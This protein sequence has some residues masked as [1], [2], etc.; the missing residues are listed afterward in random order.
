[1]H[2]LSK[3][4]LKDFV[5]ISMFVLFL[6]FFAS[7]V[8]FAADNGAAGNDSDGQALAR[9]A[10][11][12]EET[13]F[14]DGDFLTLEKIDESTHKLIETPDIPLVAL[15]PIEAWSFANLIIALAALIIS[16]LTVITLLAGRS[17][18]AEISGEH[19]VYRGFD[20]RKPRALKFFGVCIGVASVVLFL[21]TEDVHGVT[22]AVNERTWLMALML[23]V[24]TVIV[25]A[26]FRIERRSR[27]IENI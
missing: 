10:D 7:L 14:S 6:I 18:A 24:Q 27:D 20:P 26:S 1:M 25:L 17:A 22:R 2:I 21:L 23:V 3:H 16:A 11:A 13:L 9:E 12:E 19:D 15:P 4:T 8:A 5:W